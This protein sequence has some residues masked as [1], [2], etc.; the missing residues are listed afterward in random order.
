[1]AISLLAA[2]TD[3]KMTR[4]EVVDK[5]AENGVEISV[6]TLANYEQGRTVPN[7]VVAKA[8]AEVY[9]RSVDDIRFF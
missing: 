5:L 1:M 3:V 4:Q 7:V 9:G 8:L 6:N 2:R